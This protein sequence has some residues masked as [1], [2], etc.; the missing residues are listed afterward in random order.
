M[1]RALSGYVSAI[2]LALAQ[3]VLPASAFAQ[4]VPLWATVPDFPPL[5]KPDRSGF[6]E[7]DGARLYYA[8][9]NARGHAPVVLLHGGFASSDTWGFEVPRLAAG[10]EVIVMD[11]RGHGR[12]SLGDKPLG[13][14]QMAD[15]VIAVLDANGVAKASIVGL[16]DGGITGLLLGIRYPD[17]INR[18]FVWGA[19]FNTH[20]DS[21]APDDPAMKGMGA[22]FMARMQANYRAVSPTPDGFPALRAALGRLYASEPNLTPAQLGSIRAPTVIADGAHEQFIAREHTEALAQF[23]PGARLL[24]VPNVSHGGPQQDP[25]AFH[26]AVSALLDGPR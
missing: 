25:A 9:F 6:V 2:L 14:G 20:A 8:V 16:S 15:D 5:P 26:A 22:I 13:Y 24:I 21:T 7:R 4:S 3:S 12:S 1:S 18:L 19:S 10:H 23:I 11:S 17:R